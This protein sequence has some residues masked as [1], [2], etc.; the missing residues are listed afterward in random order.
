M[1]PSTF[2]SNNLVF[3]FNFD[4][5]QRGGSEVPETMSLVS[6]FVDTEKVVGISLFSVL[7]GIFMSV[8]GFVMWLKL[9]ITFNTCEFKHIL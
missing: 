5:D 9:S 7:E 4:F 1:E 6:H 8:T 3:V 2:I